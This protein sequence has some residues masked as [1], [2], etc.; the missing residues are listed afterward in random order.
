MLT[1][2][3][4]SQNLSI[5]LGQIITLDGVATNKSNPKLEGVTINLDTKW[6]DTK[7][8]VEPESNKA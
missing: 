3:E 5:E 6:L 8:C 2:K 7:E 4:T 1:S